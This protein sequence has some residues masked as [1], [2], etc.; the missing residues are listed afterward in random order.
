MSDFCSL[1]QITID[2]ITAQ[3]NF[4][5]LKTAIEAARAGEQGRGFAVVA[6]EVRTLAS[7][8]T[9]ATHE[10]S[11]TIGNIKQQ[12]KLSIATLQKNLV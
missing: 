10:I 3:T 12:A 2:D 5:A 4:L 6:D 7:R 11:K 8:I 1:K 9:I